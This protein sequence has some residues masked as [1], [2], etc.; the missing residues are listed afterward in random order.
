[1]CSL[2]KYNFQRMFMIKSVCE[3][4]G[5]GSKGQRNRKINR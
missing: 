4:E 5:G 2:K 3:R 1:M